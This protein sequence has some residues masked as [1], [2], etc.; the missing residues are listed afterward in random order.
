MNLTEG[1][2]D[3][4]ALSAM[5]NE[6]ARRNLSIMVNM[7]VTLP[8]DDLPRSFVSEDNKS[9]AIVKPMS[10]AACIQRC[11]FIG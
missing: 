9:D 4:E 2:S 1:M 7:K 5:V 8:K 10:E 11:H 3:Q 6:C